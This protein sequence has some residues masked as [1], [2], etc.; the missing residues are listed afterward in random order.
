MKR[1]ISFFLILLMLAAAFVVEAAAA[2]DSGAVTSQLRSE[3][4]Y[5]ENLD[6]GTVFFDK[7]SEKQISL[8]GFAKVIS[9]MVALEKWGNL[10]GNVKITKAHLNVF[11]QIYGMTTALYAEG[12][13]VS[14]RELFDCLVVCSANDA[15]S[16][17]AY[18]TYGTEEEFIKQMQQLVARIGCT[19]TAVKNMHGFDQEGQYTTA[20]DVAKLMKHAMTYPAL[21]EALGTDEVTLQKTQKNEK[22]TY[23]SSNQMLSGAVEDYYHSAVI[24]GKHTST[25][26]AGECMA[27]VSNADGY[28]YLTVVMGG[29]YVDIDDDGYD[30]NTSMTDTQLML[31]WVYENIRFKVIAVPEQTVATVD[32]IAGKD[33][34]KLVLVPEKETS[35]LVPMAATP[36]SVMFEFVGGLPESIVAPIKEGEIIGQ[37]NIYYAGHKLSTINVVAKEGVK[38]SFGGLI[39]TGVKAV[40]GSVFFMVLTF[41]AAAVG[42]L[43]L[44][45]DVKDFFDKERRKSFDPLPSSFETLTEKFKSALVFDKSKI[46]KSLSGKTTSGKQKKAPEKKQSEV[47]IRAAGKGNNRPQK[48]PAVKNEAAKNHGTAKP[49]Q[50]RKKPVASQKNSE[51]TKRAGAGKTQ[52]KSKK[53]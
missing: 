17:I 31:D 49:V 33:G 27:A 50:K 10:D 26:L 11:E 21:S 44:V 20:K 53:E 19:A 15:L 22:R 41:L 8:A 6:Q 42:V 2:I 46:K 5:M 3:I 1:L 36:A 4:Y 18:D 12:E 43:K 40:V 13:T 32:I 38:L 7:D 37:A 14:R 39:L 48:R 16:I 23:F 9:A 30:E 29:E 52:N 35:A 45:L 28:S 51:A 25:E 24:A 34:E 47:K